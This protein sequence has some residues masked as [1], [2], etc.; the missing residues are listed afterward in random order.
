MGGRCTAAVEMSIPVRIRALLG[1]PVSVR[2]HRGR[3]GLSPP[4]AGADRRGE[5]V[6]R[7]APTH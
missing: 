4:L 2:R 6:G 1:G 3:G 7:G 5:V